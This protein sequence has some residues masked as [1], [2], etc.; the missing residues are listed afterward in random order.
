MALA[1][2]RKPEIPSHE[3][4]ALRHLLG[5]TWRRGSRP[6]AD[7][8]VDVVGGE[9]ATEEDGRSSAPAPRRRH[10]CARPCRLRSECRGEQ[11][12][13]DA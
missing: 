5:R 2:V 4:E 8:C 10:T 12:G 6:L 11:R 7:E 3:M 9:A 1:M 13:A